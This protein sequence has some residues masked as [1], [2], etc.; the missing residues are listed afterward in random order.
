VDEAVVI[1]DGSGN[2]PQALIDCVLTDGGDFARTAELATTVHE[3]IESRLD[4][5]FDTADATVR[6]L[7]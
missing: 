5:T 7:P 3:Q 1:V 4:L 2:A 6:N